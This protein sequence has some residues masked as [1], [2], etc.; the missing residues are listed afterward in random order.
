MGTDKFNPR[1]GPAMDKH[2]T[3]GGS[4]NISSRFMLQKPGIPRRPDRPLSLY[5]GFTFYNL[6]L[7][8]FY[9]NSSIRRGGAGTL[10]KIVSTAP[11]LYHKAS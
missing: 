3:L 8:N 1:V 7:N 4:R 5:A 9:K 2:P 6:A 10:V 11:S